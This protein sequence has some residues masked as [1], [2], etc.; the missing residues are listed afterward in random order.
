M[1]SSEIQP[2]VVVDLQP[3]LVPRVN[4]HKSNWGVFPVQRQMGSGGLRVKEAGL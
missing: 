3:Q 2:Q 4:H 1:E